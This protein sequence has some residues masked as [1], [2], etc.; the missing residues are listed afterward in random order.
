MTTA[1]SL[2]EIARLVSD[3]FPNSEFCSSG[4]RIFFTFS[5]KAYESMHKMDIKIMVRNGWFYDKNNDCWSI[6]TD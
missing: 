6:F 2:V 4:K 3:H 1:I 5:E